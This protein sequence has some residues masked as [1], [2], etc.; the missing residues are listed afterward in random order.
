[1]KLAQR[2]LPIARILAWSLFRRSHQAM[3]LQSHLKTKKQL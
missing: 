1:M 3:A 2:R